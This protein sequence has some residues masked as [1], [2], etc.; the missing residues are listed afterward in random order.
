MK[1][2]FFSP[3]AYFSVH[4][5]PEALVAES[6][7][8]GNC[9][10]VVVNCDGLYH[11][12]C[13][14]M[15]LIDIDD[16]E[17]KT[18][19]CVCCKSNRDAINKEF[20]FRSVN[21]DRYV[22]RDWRRSVDVIIESVTPQNYLD[23][24]FEAIPIAKYALYEFVLNHKLSSTTIPHELW[25]EY[26]ENLRNSLLTYAGMKTL[27]DEEKPDRITTYNSLYS[28]N[29]IACAVAD[30]VEIPHFT[31]HAGSHHKKRI[32]QMTIFKGINN[33][34]LVNL[35]PT[36][37]ITRQ[38]PLNEE[39]IAAVNDHVKQ[40]FEAT[41]PWVYTT[42]SEKLS[43]TDLRSRLGIG[44]AQKVLLAV[45][46]SNDERFGLD[47][48]GMH[49]FDANPIFKSQYEWLDWLIDF[50]EKNPNYFVIFRVHPREYP[51]K[52]ERKLSQNAIRFGEYV[53][54]IKAPSNFS[55][56]TPDDRLSLHDLLKIADV[57]LNNTSSVGLEA[58]L[59]GIPV[60]GVSERLYA[61]DPALQLEPKSIQDYEQ[62]INAAI[63]RGI[64]F[65]RVILAYR[66]LNYVFSEVCIDISDGY[67]ATLPWRWRM[68]SYIFRGLRRLGFELPSKS[69]IGHVVKRA[70]PLKEA[71]YLRYAITNVTDSH[72]GALPR[73]RAAGD[74]H[75]ERKKIE[76]A[77]LS[78]MAHIS[79]PE[80]TAF[81]KRTLLCI[82]TI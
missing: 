44:A 63:L 62:K 71:A 76:E 54:H 11:R 39:E 26:L 49:L 47:L 1:I 58:C 18:K 56:N 46:R 37:Q 3:H 66:W 30:L 23:L 2:L 55:I 17:Q 59:F 35:H 21:I 80:D 53:A 79:A 29:R 15:P 68:A 70:K 69:F 32:Q 8:L 16:L 57:V 45:M 64:S 24:E 61:F 50:S 9:E 41:S 10:I 12:N 51:N 25:P 14:C 13:V 42:K 33:S 72:I 81:Q 82:S 28:V 19:I 20:G 27:L 67:A 38:A 77:F 7:S 73:L 31:L 74:K 6:L 43:S 78:I 36:L 4:A 40:L 22:S 60:I 34:V 48:A 5:L 65:E 75:Q 52:R